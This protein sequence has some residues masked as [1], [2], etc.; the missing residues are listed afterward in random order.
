MCPLRATAAPPVV[1]KAVPDDGATNVDPALKELRVVFDQT[2]SPDGMSIVGGGPTFPKFTGKPHWENNRTLVYGWRLEPGHDYWLSINNDD[3]TNFRG[4]NDE[5]AVPH[6]ISF[7]TSGSAGT[8]VAALPAMNRE[9]A[10][11]LKQAIDD[12]YSFRDLRHVDWEKRFKEFTPQLESATDA[13][14]F[15]EVAARLIEPAGDVHFWLEVD[16]DIISAFRREAPWNVATSFLP[17]QIPHW[18]KRNSIVATGMFDDGIRYISIRGW[19]AGSG[20]ELAPAFEAVTE[21]ADA[22]HPLMIDVR[23]N[24]GGS[25]NLAQDFAGCFVDHPVVYA[26]SST[27]YD[28]KWGGVRSSNGRLI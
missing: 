3:F 22:G 16:N 8:N 2:M 18:Q 14:K 25:E 10:M 17:R 4:T 27:R 20:D 12:D 6:P 15:A 5:S 21:A 19:P 7:H 23:A 13:R 26:K 1:A 24:G 11:L 28:G 9:A